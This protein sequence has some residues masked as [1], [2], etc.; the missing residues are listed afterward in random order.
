[1]WRRSLLASLALV[2][3]VFASLGAWHATALCEDNVHLTMGNPSGATANATDKH[4]YLMEKEYFVLSY[5]NDKGRPNWVSWHL[6][7]DDLGDAPRKGFK[8][9]HDLPSGFLKITTKDYT[10]GGFDRGHMCPHSDRAA[11]DESS[12]ATF[13]MTNI[14]P[15]SAQVNQKAWAQLEDYCRSL[16]SDEG[17]ELYIISGPYGRGGR[18]KKGFACT[19]AHGKV[20]VPAHC[21]KVIMVL[22]AKKGNDIKRVDEDTRLI[23]VVMPNDTTVGEDWGRFRV[24]VKDVEELTGYTFFSN[25]DPKIIGPLK[26]TVDDEEIEAQAPII[27]ARRRPR[28]ANQ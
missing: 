6:E 20:V 8:A 15:Q 19:I 27:H 7:K 16:V 24:S 2:T 28:S 5:D 9:D 23:A 1:M 26:E 21:W 14:I 3:L 18:G 17:K 12:Q 13:V 10:G 11:T 4:N 25:V 22:D